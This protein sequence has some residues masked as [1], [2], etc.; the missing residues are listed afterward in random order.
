MSE[1]SRRRVAVVGGGVVGCAVAF[2]LAQAGITVTLFEPDRLGS[3]ASGI[4]A[5]N[6]NPLHGTPPAL[7][8]FALAAFQRHREVRSALEQ[9]AC[10]D[11]PYQPAPRIHLGFAETDRPAL[12]ETAALFASH[13]GFS[14]TWLDDKALRLHEPRLGVE[15]R[16]GFLAMGNQWTDSASFTRSL[17]QGALKLGA[18]WIQTRAVG[19]ATV[20][21]R[22]TGIQ[23]ESGV[24]ACDAAVFAT[25]PWVAPVEHW[26]G[27]ELAV[28]PVKGELLLMRLPEDRLLFDL[29]GGSHALYQR[30]AGEVWVGDTT[31]SRGF[32]ETP[33][34]AT[35]AVLL[36]GVA[37]IL[38]AIRQATLLDHVAALRP[39]TA[40]RL[41][42]VG[43]APG[44]QNA[45]IANG[46]G[47]KGLLL[48]TG[49]A[50]VIRDLVLDGHT[51]LPLKLLGA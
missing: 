2:A 25:G 36:D 23:T 39:M 10:A 35:Q 4:N 47:T 7:I 20:G 1:F 43:R 48:S 32:D 9:L 8:P 13:Q 19:L 27:I 6:L 33:N 14:A 42:L 12:A 24:I 50:Q 44:W 46:G 41:P 11:Y 16:F 21:D 38:P 45:Y 37:R 22:V 51:S 29:I 26:L 49:I 3:H 34:P 28:E 17:A 31:E 30:R 5:G 40:S 15:V 18:E